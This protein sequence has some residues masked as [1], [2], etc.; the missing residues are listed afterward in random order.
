MAPN[1]HRLLRT[2]L[3]IV[4]FVILL[5]TAYLAGLGNAQKMAADAYTAGY[6]AAIEERGLPP[7]VDVDEDE[8]P[9]PIAVVGVVQTV[10]ADG[11]TITEEI[12]GSTEP[13]PARTVVLTSGGVVIGLAPKDPAILARE[14]AAYQRNTNGPPPV[15]DVQSDIALSDLKPGDRVTVLTLDP[16][17][18]PISAERITRTAAAPEPVVAPAPAEPAGEPEMMPQ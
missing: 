5:A 9:E 1:I 6:D 14:L 3:L 4:V 8:P 13:G 2:G 15:P 12:P 10:N 16:D 11:L 7:L 17:S 18:D